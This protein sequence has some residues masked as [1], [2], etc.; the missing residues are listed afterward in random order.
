MITLRGCIVF[1]FQPFLRSTASNQR[2]HHFLRRG[3]AGPADGTLPPHFFLDSVARPPS[4]QATVAERVAARQVQVVVRVLEAFPARAVIDDCGSSALT[5]GET[6][7]LVH[8]AFSVDVDYDCAPP[9][10]ISITRPRLGTQMTYCKQILRCPAACSP[11]ASLAL[12]SSSDCASRKPFTS[13]LASSL[14][15]VAPSGKSRSRVFAMVSGLV[16]EGG[17]EGAQQ[18]GGSDM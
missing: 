2:R 5:C 12:A 16:Y 11:T 4:V 17:E 3:D 14:F 7:S 8:A 15:V 13:F 10:S 18:K 1:V 9:S 6:M